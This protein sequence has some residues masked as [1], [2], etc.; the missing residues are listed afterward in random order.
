M[1]AWAGAVAPSIPAPIPTVASTAAAARVREA[2]VRD[3]D[4]STFLDSDPVLTV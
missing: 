4:M 2:R 1:A 3:I